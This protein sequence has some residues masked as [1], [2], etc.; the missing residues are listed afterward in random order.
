MRQIVRAVALVVGLFLLILLAL[1]FL[2]NANQ[3]RPV[4]EEYLSAALGRAVKVGDLRLALLSGGVAADDLSIADDPSFSA[5]PFVQAKSL[6]VGVEM[7]PLISSRRLNVT[8]ISID[9]PAIALIQSESGAW[10][11]LIGLCEEQ[12]TRF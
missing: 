10:N 12:K 7:W 8:T 9:Q 11:F 4:I 6:K 2:I 1:P 3:F 5:I